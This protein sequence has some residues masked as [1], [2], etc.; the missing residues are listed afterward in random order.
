MFFTNDTLRF[1]RALKRN[2]DRE[3]FKARRERYEAHVREPM[4]ALIERL[5]RDLPR[6]AP[7]IVASPRTSLYRVYRDTRFSDDKTPLK[8][9]ASASFRWRGLDK[10]E[11]AG[12]YLE[13]HPQWVWMGGGFW[14]P[15]TR[16]LV[17][18]RE[19]IAASYPELDRIVR[20]RS[21]RRIGALEGDRLQRVPRGYSKDDPAAEYLKF[22]QFLVGREFPAQFAA[23]AEFYPALLETYRGIMPLI[24]FLNEPLVEKG[25]QKLGARS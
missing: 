21:L 10:G 9:Q 2:N 11:G 15:E 19:H 18:I 24:R 13:V 20:A 3:W 4:I 14:A 17:K 16:H 25:S 8:I 5:A 12:L 23:S 6:F 22:R 7:E 1:L